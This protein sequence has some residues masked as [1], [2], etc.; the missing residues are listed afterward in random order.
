MEEAS[1]DTMQSSVVQRKLVSFL[2]FIKE[3]FTANRYYNIGSRE[4]TIPGRLQEAIAY[5]RLA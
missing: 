2:P 5:G 3:N 1:N 4:A